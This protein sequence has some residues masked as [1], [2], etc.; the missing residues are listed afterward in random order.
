MICA[1]MIVQTGIKEVI[2]YQDYADI[3]ARDFL[4]NNGVLLRKAERPKPYID[5]KD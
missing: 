3:D 1:K 2:S 4:M 5:F